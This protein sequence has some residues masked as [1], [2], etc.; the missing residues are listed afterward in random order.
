MK[1]YLKNLRQIV[2]G[3]SNLIMNYER[4]IA[5]ERSKICAECPLFENGFCSKNKEFNGIKGCSCLISAKSRCLNC[6][7]PLDSWPKNNNL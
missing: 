6:T 5:F 1:K 4:D 2:E 7:C 3:Y